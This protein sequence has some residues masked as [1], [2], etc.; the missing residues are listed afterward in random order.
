MAFP[1]QIIPDLIKGLLDVIRPSKGAGKPETTLLIILVA[2]VFGG[3]YLGVV[4]GSTVERVVD[5]LIG[6][7]VGNG[8]Q[9]RSVARKVVGGSPPSV[10]KRR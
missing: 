4:E 9:R 6:V 7:L 8:Y 5:V 1:V 10:L 2:L 3:S